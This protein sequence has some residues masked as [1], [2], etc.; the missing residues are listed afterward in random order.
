MK[1]ASCGHS[2]YQSAQVESMD[3]ASIMGEEYAAKAQAA[4]G[5]QIRNE[6]A[7]AAA[8]GQQRVQAAALGGPRSAAPQVVAAPIGGGA[9]G[10]PGGPPV[11]AGAVSLMNRGAPGGRPQPNAAQSSWMQKNA[12]PGQQAPGQAGQSGAPGAAGGPAAAARWADSPCAVKPV[13]ER[14]VLAP[15][16]G[17]SQLKAARKARPAVRPCKVLRA[18]QAA[19][20]SNLPVNPCPVN[21]CKRARKAAPRQRRWAVNPYAA[22]PAPERSVLDLYHGCSPLKAERQGRRE[23]FPV[24]V[25]RPVRKARP[26]Q[27]CNP[28]S[29]CLVRLGRP[30]VPAKPRFRGCSMNAAP[31]LLR[32]SRCRAVRKPAQEAP[33]FHK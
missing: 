20:A 4:A 15:Y 1:C 9:S 30:R 25:P 18:L 10:A 2:W 11:P 33:R 13:P 31:Q 5:G 8:G 32:G 28:V 29:R 24:P 6:V 16:R 19:P 7:P 14:S 21:R 17:C 12:P 23:A 27:R 22:K 26:A 3:L